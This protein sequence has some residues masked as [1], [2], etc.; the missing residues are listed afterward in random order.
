MK[1]YYIYTA[2]V[3][4]GGADRV[5]AEKANWLAEH[6]YEIAIVTDT[7]LGREPAFPLSPKVKLIDLAID[8]SKEYGHSFPVRVWMYY[9]L[10]RQYRKKMKVLLMHDR[11]DIVISILGRDISFITKIKDGSKKI[12]EAHT[13][14]H[15]IRNFHL[16]ENKNFLLK[17]LTKYFRWNMDRQVKRLDAL[18]V[19]TSQDKEDWGHLLP[20]YVIPNSYPFYPEVPSTCE[21]KQ[22]IIVGR[23]NSAK[24]Y[25]YLIDAWR[26]VY[27]KHP[28]WIINIFG[29]GEYEDKVRKQIND[30]GLQDVIIMNNP[31]DHIMEEYLKSSIYVMSSVFEGFAMVLLEAMACGLPCVSFDCPYG[32]RNIITD[33]ED[34]YL[35]DYLNSKALADKICILIDNL[36]IRQR[37]GKKGRENV[38]RFSRETIMSHWVSLFNSIR[39]TE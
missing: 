13:T 5:I 17:F 6:G 25:N 9:K 10:M 2:L 16:L 38:L 3:T 24:G 11:P 21:N 34:G 37:M 20:V 15:F 19:L 26:D 32:P 23:Y 31:T 36:E 4:K 1:I 30:Y 39:N 14:K 8:F 7:Q 18:V 29:S 22:A 33:C 27:K 35:V 28:D 12:G